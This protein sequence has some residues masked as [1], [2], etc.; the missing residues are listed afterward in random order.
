MNI[1]AANIVEIHHKQLFDTKWYK[2]IIMKY[3]MS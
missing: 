2:C 3:T 1:L